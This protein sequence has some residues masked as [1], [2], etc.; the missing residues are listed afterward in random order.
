MKES[1]FVEQVQAGYAFDDPCLE[2][3][4]LVVDGAPVA[5]A[6]IR[7]PLSMLNRHGLVAGATGTGKTK[8]LQVMAEQASAA[9]VPCLA[10]D[11]KGDLSGLASPGVPNEKIDERAQGIGQEWQPTA[12]PVELLRL[13]DNGVG[14]PVRASITSFGPTLLSKVL[15][16]NDT[17][18]SSLGLVFYYADQAGLP[19]VDLGDLRSV[20]QHLIS[21]EGK[22]DLKG[23]GGLSKSTA[24]VILRELI[25]FAA[26]GADT[27]FGEPE[28]DVEDLLRNTDD[29]RGIVTLLELPTVQDQPVL[30]STFLMW[31]LAELFE[32]LPE[33]GDLD[34]PKLMFFFD[35]AHLLFKDA[36]KDF[37][38]SLIQ[39]VRLIR[40]KGVGVFFVTQTPKDVHEDVLAQLGSRI[41]HQLRAFTPNDAAALKAT[42]RTYPTSD[43][44]LEQLLQSVGIGEAVVTVMSEKGAPTPVAHTMIPAPQSLM[45]PSP[46]EVLNEIVTQSPL[47]SKYGERI[48]RESAFEMLSGKIESGPGGTADSAEPEVGARDK[49]TEIERL[50]AEILGTP[51]AT[52]VPSEPKAKSRSAPQSSAFDDVLKTAAQTLAKEISRGVFGTLRRR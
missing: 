13:G 29:G 10:A 27:F 16:L 36:S 52:T 32:V 22:A 23:I 17:Q 38:S 26:T 42:V 44:D 43:Y 49:Q 12:F 3:G 41:Q 51:T 11:I 33:V 40:S 4:A 18:E 19:L 6:R 48:D 24:N 7:V 34:K 50:E 2:L 39:T 37:L 35:E 47:C 30:F 25:N 31:L 14:V 28:F 8:T 1:E 5:G 9:G 45:D 15:E 21:D 46:D 20:I